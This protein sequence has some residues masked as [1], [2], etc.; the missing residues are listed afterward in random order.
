MIQVTVTNRNT[1]VC[2]KKAI[3]LSTDLNQD[4]MVVFDDVFAFVN[5]DSVASQVQGEL[6]EKMSS[7]NFINSIIRP[8]LK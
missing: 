3:R 1:E 2:I 8:R 7:R 4:V 5:K 6:Y